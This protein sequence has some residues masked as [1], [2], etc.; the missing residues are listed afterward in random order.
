MPDT[1]T[2][3][4]ATN[5]FAAILARVESGREFIVTRDGV[6][7][8]RI[9]PMSLSTE[10]SGPA[11]TGTDWNRLRPM[12]DE[13]IKRAVAEDPDAAAISTPEE[14]MEY[15]PAPARARH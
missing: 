14:M 15:K 11:E 9:V 7:I 8:A 13:D 12:T 6:M 2:A 10:R 5:D 1:I 3:N 4:E